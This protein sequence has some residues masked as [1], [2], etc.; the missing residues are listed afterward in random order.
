MNGRKEDGMKKFIARSA[1]FAASLCLALCGAGLSACG[2]KEEPDP[3]KAETHVHNYTAWTTKEKATCTEPGLQERTCQNPGC[4]EDERVVTREIP[5]LG[6]DWDEGVPVAGKTAS[7]TEPGEML[8]T[9]NA[10]GDHETRKIPAFG[11][12]WRLLERTKE[13]TCTQPGEESH[14]C[15]V[16]KTVEEGAVVPALGHAWETV[17]FTPATCTEPGTR[18]RTCTRCGERSETDTDPLGHNWEAYYTVDVPATFD[19]AGEKSYHCARCGERDEARAVVIPQLNENTPIEYEFRLLRNNG[20]AVTDRSITVSVFGEDGEEVARSRSST[21]KDGVFKAELLPRKYTVK[22]DPETLPAGYTADAVYE[23]DYEDPVCKL[24]LTASPIEGEAGSSVRY[25]VGSVM[26]DFSYETL[27]GDTIVLSELLQEYKLVVLNFFYTGC[28][29]CRTEFPGLVNAYE[30]YRED[31]C[32]IAIDPDP[33]GGD[34]EAAIR[35]FA[36]SFNMTFFVVRDTTVRLHARFGISSYPQTAFI[37]RE[38]VVAEFHTEAIGTSAETS[39]RLFSSIFEKYT[40]DGYWQRGSEERPAL[41]Q[42]ALPARRREE[43]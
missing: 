12:T 15:T 43:F 42:A 41:S 26:H 13:P 27:N 3:P 2:K 28:T 4:P 20:A 38:G 40:A 31:V 16:C 35:A 39:E 33:Y 7:C 32:V 34:G 30:A 14:M 22:I 37:D 19:H 1:L 18:T 6:H 21:L 17:N 36:S 25:S 24:W 23:V 5:A 29:W 10:C 11:H 8:Y 9:C